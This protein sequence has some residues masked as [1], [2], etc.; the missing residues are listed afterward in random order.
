MEI[1]E[2]T[3]HNDKG[4]NTANVY[5]FPKGWPWEKRSPRLDTNE[6]HHFRTFWVPA[7]IS[8][9]PNLPSTQWALGAHTPHFTGEQLSPGPHRVL[10]G[11]QDLNQICVRSPYSSATLSLPA[12]LL[13]GLKVLIRTLNVR[14]GE[15]VTFPKLIHHRILTL[16]NT[17][18]HLDEYSV[19]Q[20]VG[21]H[22]KRPPLWPAQ[23]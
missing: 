22:E 13:R 5:R 20:N 14:E 6:S 1:E 18:W 4:G 11:S 10:R 3:Y 16:R 15:S 21:R 8:F 7:I 9:N 23:L 12:V 17:Q 19:P 2:Y